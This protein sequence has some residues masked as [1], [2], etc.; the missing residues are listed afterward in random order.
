VYGYV[1]DKALRDDGSFA[2]ASACQA[3]ARFALKQLVA[4]GLMAVVWFV[5]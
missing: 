3:F 4:G 1:D 2:A 5:V